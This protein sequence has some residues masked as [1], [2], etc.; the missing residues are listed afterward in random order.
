MWVKVLLVAALSVGHAFSSPDLAVRLPTAMN[1]TMADACRKLVTVD[2][3]CTSIYDNSGFIAN[4]LGLEE[5][6]RRLIA[7]LGGSIQVGYDVLQ[8]PQEGFLHPEESAMAAPNASVAFAYEKLALPSRSL[9]Q[10]TVDL[11]SHAASIQTNA[12]YHLS[13]LN[14]RQRTLCKIRQATCQ[15]TDDNYVYDTTGRNVR[16]YSV[17]EAVSKGH[18]DFSTVMSGAT[19]VSSD[20]FVFSSFIPDMNQTCSKW[21]GTHVAALAAGLMHGVAKD[22]TVVS[23]AVKPGCRKLSTARALA[24]GL[25]WLKKHAERNPGRAVVLVDTKVSV[26]QPN[27]V[28]IDILED[29]F[30]DLHNMGIAIVTGAGTG[31]LNACSFTPLRL[32]FVI[33]VAGAEVVRLPSKVIARPWDRTNYGE[34][35]TIYAQAASMESAFAPGLSDTAVYSGTTQAAGITAGV[36]AALLERNPSDSIETLTERLVNVSSTAYLMYSLPDTVES[37]LQLPLM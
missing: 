16:I 26:L 7:V 2:I 23:V 31:S 3:A 11:P 21:Q 14:S 29:L 17:G 25:Y 22:S 12:P 10:I 9:M 35:V 36:L 37:I 5:G 32:P 6:R 20:E 4:N 8:D 1:M 30:V 27:G 28:A 13:F 19:R 15:F 24:D 34:C 33:T 18:I